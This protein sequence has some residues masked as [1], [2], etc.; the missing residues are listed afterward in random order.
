VILGAAVVVFAI[1]YFVP[2]DPAEIMLGASATPEEITAKRVSLGLDQPFLIQ[3][4]S[5]LYNA[6]VRFDLGVSWIRGTSVMGGLLERLPR[7]FLLGLLTV[8][9]TIAVG[10]PFGVGAAI[11]RNGWQDRFLI[12]SAI[13]FSS[14][15]EFW[16]AL[17]MIIVFSLN[18]KW[19]PSFGIE[20]WACYVLPVIAGSISGI[21]NLARQTRA[22]VLDVV[23]TDYVTTAR[24]KGMKEQRVIYRHVFPNALIPII[25]VLG[26]SF[27]RCVG[28]TIIIERIFSFPGVGLYLS[29]AISM[30]DYPIIRGCVVFM[31]AFTSLLMLLVDLAYG[32][33]NP[34]IKAQYI[35][36]GRRKN[37][38][39][40]RKRHGDRQ[41]Q[42]RQGYRGEDESW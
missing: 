7:T 23:R 17:M 19:L 36:S 42:G 1:M 5:F 15:P 18:L 4:G 12:I 21:C 31:A 22:S 30:R 33:A 3:L 41:V 9:L 11:H 38:P 39:H 20:T 40:G 28:G 37:R 13:F 29:D 34:Q 6:F 14:V 27:V 10:I 25:T 8:A 2:G 26:D 35:D 32:Y 16:L 24:S